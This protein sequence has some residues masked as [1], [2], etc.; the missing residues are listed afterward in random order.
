MSL[1]VS[2]DLVQVSFSP[3]LEVDRGEVMPLDHAIER[4]LAGAEEA[5]KVPGGLSREQVR[6][7][8]SKFEDHDKHLLRAKFKPNDG[9]P[10]YGGYPFRRPDTGFHMDGRPSLT[11]IHSIF[12][13]HQTTRGAATAQFVGTA[14]GHKPSLINTL[15]TPTDGTVHV[16]PES[17][18]TNGKCCELIRGDVVLFVAL[19]MHA[20]AHGFRSTTKKRS[21]TIRQYSKG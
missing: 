11:R 3:V 17:F 8:D 20:V 12:H 18:A 21:A 1:E 13:S 14:S 19:G 4:L 10:Y 5:V 9:D 6:L 16:D 2:Q 15:Q 7:I